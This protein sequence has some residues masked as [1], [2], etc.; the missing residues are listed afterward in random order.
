MKKYIYYIILGLAILGSCRSDEFS[1]TIIEQTPVEEGEL[2]SGDVGGLVIDNLG[3]GI[4]SAEVN[5]SGESRMTDANGYFRFTDIDVN[6]EG[7]VLKVTKNSYF[8]NYKFVYT[9]EDVQSYVQV[10]MVKAKESGRFLAE[11]TGTITDGSGAE[12]LFAANSIAQD[13]I[14]YTGEVIVHSHYYDPTS[15]ELGATMPGDLRGVSSR[16][17]PVQ[18]AT[19]GMMA[20][21]LS[22]PEGA[23]LQLAEGKTATL[24]FPL[25]PEMANE[26]TGEVPLWSLNESTGIWEEEGSSVL[27]GNSMVGEVSHFSFWNCDL[28]FPFVEI[29]G[30]LETRS[31]EGIPNFPV[32]IRV[33]SSLTSASSVTDNN[34]FFQG[35]VPKDEP[36]ELIVNFCGE[37][38]ISRDLGIISEDR[39]LGS[40]RTDDVSEYEKR[41]TGRLVDCFSEPLA[42]GYLL[43]QKGNTTELILPDAM[44]E[45][46][47]VI[48][49]CGTTTLRAVDPVDILSS[50]EITIENNNASLELGDIEVCREITERIVYSINGGPNNIIEEATVRLV[51]NKLIHLWGNDGELFDIRFELNGP[52]TVVPSRI[53]LTGKADNN[54]SVARACG[55]IFLNSGIICDGL[56]VTVTEMGGVG[57]MVRG[58]ITGTMAPDQSLPAID[59]DAE[60]QFYLDEAFSTGSVE[61]KV[62]HDENENGI[63]E[64]DEGPIRG[65]TMELTGPEFEFNPFYP[66][67]DNSV[68]G[69]LGY[70]VFEGL[71]P[72]DNYIV[73]WIPEPFFRATQANQGDD[74][75]D[76][77]F[78][79]VTGQITSS[80]NY[81][82]PEVVESELISNID[83]GLI[84]DSTFFC[85]FEVTGC[86]PNNGIAITISGG[87][88]PYQYFLNGIPSTTQPETLSPGVYTWRIVDSNG[89]ECTE[90]VTVEEFQNLISTQVW[91]DVEGGIPDVLDASDAGFDNA[92]LTLLKDGLLEQR[93][94]TD[95][96]GRSLF[97][98]VPPGD[99]Q[100]EITVPTGYELVKMSVGNDES[101]DSDIDPDTGLSDIITVLDCEEVFFVKIGLREI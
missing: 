76:S 85:Q 69:D 42:N 64:D 61:G 79:F 51:N 17:E 87:T 94:F 100:V 99:Y 74:T 33:Q 78:E 68:T 2:V 39:N 80:Y 45:F 83:L 12:I 66:E 58:T 30:R 81:R 23:E 91:L 3:Q 5:L 82:I 18:L 7:G 8:D 53:A 35:K 6:S 29:V 70:Y 54:T 43:V 75:R 22:T 31:G 25:T 101:A 72:G 14:L 48:L 65:M 9:E 13:G 73:Q 34:G 26:V 67:T 21:E 98:N 55:S 96:L 20:V 49:T 4:A 27:V 16:N 1:E 59:I 97:Q 46:S 50:N 47:A 95:P 41:I 32:T 15:M 88:P 90:Q 84:A 10:S 92:E 93:T 28:P 44:G 60:F 19:L 62:W 57:E 89:L 86:W 24:T 52:G 63:R 38:I 77:D 56:E 11:N 40:F 37:T 71:A 36:L